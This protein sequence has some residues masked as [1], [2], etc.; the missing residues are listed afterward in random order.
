MLW[1][2]V[3]AVLK[4]RGGAGG[5]T[6]HL[7]IDVLKLKPCY[8]IFVLEFIFRDSGSLELNRRSGISMFTKLPGAFNSVYQPYSE[9][10]CF[11]WFPKL[12]WNLHFKDIPLEPLYPFA[13]PTHFFILSSIWPLCFE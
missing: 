5:M 3:T 9:Q 10:Q 8:N 12:N 6:K 4:D 7:S 2:K 11:R 1:L 13:W